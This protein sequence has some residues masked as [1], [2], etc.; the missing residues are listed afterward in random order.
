TKSGK[1]IVFATLE[2]FTGQGE[3]VCFSTTFDRVGAWVAVDNVVL[4][5]GEAEVRGGSVKIVA[6]DVI[7]MWKV[8][9]QLVKSI[10]LRVDPELAQPEALEQL[11]TLCDSN[12]GRCKLYFDVQDPSL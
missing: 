6:Q 11:R 5:K 4:V 8:R 3:M 12:R 9:E 1:P 2:D 10:V 7:P